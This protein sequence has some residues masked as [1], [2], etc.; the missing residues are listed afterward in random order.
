MLESEEVLAD[1]MVKSIQESIKGD[2]NLA[3]IL[4]KYILQCHPD[5]IGEEI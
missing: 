2:K 1:F 5:I 4:L 3:I